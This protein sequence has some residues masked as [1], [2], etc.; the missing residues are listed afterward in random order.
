MKGLLGGAASLAV[1]GSLLDKCKSKEPQATEKG[2]HYDLRSS[3][4]PNIG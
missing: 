3:I 2:H 4:L 1:G